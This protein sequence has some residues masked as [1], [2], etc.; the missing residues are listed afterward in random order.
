MLRARPPPV[1]SG[2]PV[3]D[4]TVNIAV[5]IE[6]RSRVSKIAKSSYSFSEL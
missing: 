3:S 2:K 1:T 5:L 4:L 6:F